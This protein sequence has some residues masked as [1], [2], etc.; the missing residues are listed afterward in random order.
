MDTDLIYQTL[1]SIQRDVSE[2]KADVK[3]LAGE[4][5][6]VTALEKYNETQATREWIKVFVIVP[7]IAI[8]HAIVRKMGIDV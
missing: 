3:A 4:H 8:L 5:G 6:R 2:T 7:I 1:L